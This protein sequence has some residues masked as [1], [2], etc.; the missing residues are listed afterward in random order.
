MNIGG[1]CTGHDCTVSDALNIY[2]LSVA[3]GSFSGAL[4]AHH[5]DPDIGKCHQAD[6]S[7]AQVQNT[8]LSLMLNENCTFR[9]TFLPYH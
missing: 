3:D 1:V 7:S 2:H 6:W 8:L 4:Q 9:C 5:S